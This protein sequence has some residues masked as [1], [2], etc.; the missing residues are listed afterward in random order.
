MAEVDFDSVA[1]L[2]LLLG[3]G[4]IWVGAALDEGLRGSMRRR[5]RA[6]GWAAAMAVAA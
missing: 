4:L 3:L 2:L 5:L 6:G 1:D